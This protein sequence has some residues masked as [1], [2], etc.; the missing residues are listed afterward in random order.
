[1]KLN[2]EFI[3][4]NTEEGAIL[5]PTGKADFSGVVQG[6]RTFGAVLD[7]LQKETDEPA[8]IDAMCERFD[9]PEDVIAQDIRKVVSQ[10]RSIGA[11]DE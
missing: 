3:V 7:L 2:K 6:N 1:M 9:A 5:V 4:H 8:M 10:L 11:L